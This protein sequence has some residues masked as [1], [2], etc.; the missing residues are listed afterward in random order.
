MST[1]RVC[2]FVFASFAVLRVL[3]ADIVL[4]D[5]R[6][7]KE[8]KVISQSSGRVC[9]RHSE[10]LA[11]VEKYLL[12]GELAERFPADVAAVEREDA[13]LAAAAQAAEQRRLEIAEQRRQL[14][15]P[16]VALQ[17]APSPEEHA[18]RLEEARMREIRTM[19]E[20][21][22]RS[23]FERMPGSTW[24]FSSGIEV[25]D[26]EPMSGWDDQWRVGGIVGM[27]DIHSTGGLTSQSRRFDAVVRWKNGRFQVI[28]FSP[29]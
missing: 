24:V 12:T 22:A 21:Y 19:V 25:D 7:F 5:G 11:Q 15:T 4:S 27:R 28:D 17:P 1:R 13:R 29:R 8:A 26:P 16:A 3:A 2:A 6:V 23:Y 18:Q 14:H 9:I 20:S 10:G